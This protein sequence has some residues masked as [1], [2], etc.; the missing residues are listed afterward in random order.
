MTIRQEVVAAGADAIEKI[1][2]QGGAG[3]AVDV[4]IAEHDNFLAGTDGYLN[5]VCGTRQVGE[6]GWIVQ[7][8]GTDSNLL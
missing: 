2:Q 5:A 7:C 3:H 8:R 6:E 4:I 1:Q